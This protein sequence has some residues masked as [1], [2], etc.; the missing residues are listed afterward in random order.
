MGSVASSTLEDPSDSI[1][2]TTRDD[3]VIEG[4]DTESIKQEKSGISW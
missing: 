2:T 1:F 3:A 4:S